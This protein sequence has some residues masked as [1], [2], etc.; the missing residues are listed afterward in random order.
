MAVTSLRV[1]IFKASASFLRRATRDPTQAAWLARQSLCSR[2]RVACSCGEPLAPSLQQ[3]GMAAVCPTYMNAYWASEHGAIA[4]GH[5]YGTADAP[6]SADARMRAMPWVEAQVW[7]PLTDR[8]G[9]SR[10]RRRVATTAG[11]GSEQGRLVVTQPWPGMARTI[12]GDAANVGTPG[13][14]GDNKAYAA[15]CGGSPT[16]GGA[17]ASASAISRPRGP[18]ALLGER[19]LPRDAQGRRPRRLGGRGRGDLLGHDGGGRAPAVADCVV[20]GIPAR[21]R[22]APLAVLVMRAGAALGRAR[23]RAERARPRRPR[24][25]P[26][27]RPLGAGRR[28]PAHPL[29]QGDARGGVAACGGGLSWRRR[30]D[31]EPRVP[32]RAAGCARRL[33][34]RSGAGGEA[35]E[36]VKKRV[37]KVHSRAPQIAPHMR[38]WLHRS[39]VGEAATPNRCCRPSSSPRSASGSAL[40]LQQPSTRAPPRRSPKS[41]ASTR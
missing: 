25:R 15:A 34:R 8:P 28:R 10:T 17:L 1:T 11:G 12:W 41:A 4:L 29:G 9:E 39:C 36:A 14:K 30:R 7:V 24:R 22:M 23:R 33:A 37:L 35:C 40:K 3:L 13:W 38:S 2:L 20:V 26:R 18:T 21:A 31:G 6:L 19:P 32:R 27:A 5:L 16:E